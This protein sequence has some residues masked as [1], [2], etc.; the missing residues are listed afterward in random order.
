M[1]TPTKAPAKDDIPAPRISS[2]CLYTLLEILLKP[3]PKF[4]YVFLNQFGAFI[5][6][7]KKG[8][9][10]K[11]LDFNLEAIDTIYFRILPSFRRLEEFI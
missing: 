2:R 6:F 3:F 5:K 4:T 7:L 9:L 10:F 8:E 1:L 11:T